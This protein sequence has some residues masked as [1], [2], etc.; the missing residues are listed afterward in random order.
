MELL[1]ISCPG[2]GPISAP[3]V[4]AFELDVDCPDAA[5][6]CR[7]RF[8]CGPGAYDS[9]YGHGKGVGDHRETLAIMPWK[10]IIENAFYSEEIDECVFTADVEGKNKIQLGYTFMC[11]NPSGQDGLPEGFTIYKD[12]VFTNMS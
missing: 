5:S 1:R 8:E 10:S 4:V 3:L 2:G 12:Q 11:P 9:G 6:D 7:L